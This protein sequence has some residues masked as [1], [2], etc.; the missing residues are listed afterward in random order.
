MKAVPPSL[1]HLSQRKLR[2]KEDARE[3]ERTGHR[4]QLLLR[5]LSII[6]SYPLSLAQACPTILS[7]FS[8]SFTL[9]CRFSHSL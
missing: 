1:N 9:F 6:T 2:E 7:E 5:L 4:K 3:K 8:S